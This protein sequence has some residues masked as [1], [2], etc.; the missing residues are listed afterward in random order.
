YP[1]LAEAEFI[2]ITFHR[3]V[4]VFARKKGDTA[5]VFAVNRILEDRRIDLPLE[6]KDVRPLVVSGPYDNGVL[7]GYSGVV[8]A[9]GIK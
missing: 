5:I 6:F 4:C 3:D 9:A 7:G 2:P 1:F 8:L